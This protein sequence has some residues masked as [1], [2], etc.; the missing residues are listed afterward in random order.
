MLSCGARPVGKKRG[1][2]VVNVQSIVFGTALFEVE[3]K[4][5]KCRHAPTHTTY[6]RAKDE[7]DAY[8]KAKERGNGNG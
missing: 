5:S 7:L 4:R 3:Y 1:F 2:H 8:Q 6:I